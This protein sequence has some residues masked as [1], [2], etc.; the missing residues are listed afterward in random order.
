MIFL[1]EFKMGQKAAETTHN[2]NNAFGP[3]TANEHT[4]QEWFKKFYKGDKS[5]E[6]EDHS[7]LPSEVDNHQLRESSKL[8]LTAIQEVAKEFNIDQAMVI[9]HLNKLEK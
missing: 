9:Q 5:L 3:G 8:I 2:I 1:F 7:G 4:V 6:E